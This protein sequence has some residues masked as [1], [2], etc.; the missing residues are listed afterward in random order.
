MKNRKLRTVVER[1]E[2]K[3]DFEL[4]LR[5]LGDEQIFKE[6]N[7]R[8]VLALSGQ[9]NEKQM[10]VIQYVTKAQG[11]DALESSGITNFTKSSANHEK[12]GIQ[13]CYVL[14]LPL[15]LFEMQLSEGLSWRL[16]VVDTLKHM[17][18]DSFA[19]ESNLDNLSKLIHCEQR[20]G[21]PGEIELNAH[22]M[23]YLNKIAPS[24]KSKVHGQDLF[25]IAVNE[26]EKV[27]EESVTNS[28]S[29]HQRKTG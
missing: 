7:P 22:T 13:M 12:I 25:S 2:T 8:V 16:E 23:T 26:L 9:P 24:L 19:G 6:A 21:A 14:S 5:G 17:L 28:T 15:S 27:F 1:V 11:L 4:D 10:S 18:R 20:P 3:N 29:M